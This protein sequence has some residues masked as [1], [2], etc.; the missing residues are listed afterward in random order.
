MYYTYVLTASL[1][2]ARLFVNEEGPNMCK[3]GIKSRLI[4]SLV[5]GGTLR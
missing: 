3:L 5:I 4:S 2:R 1:G